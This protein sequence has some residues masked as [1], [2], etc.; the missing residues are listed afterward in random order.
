[1]DEPILHNIG[2]FVTKM[3]ESFDQKMLRRNRG[4]LHFAVQTHASVKFPWEFRNAQDCFV[5]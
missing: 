2:G 5:A 4:D 3:S 1:M